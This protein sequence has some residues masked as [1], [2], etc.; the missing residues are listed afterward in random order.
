MQVETYVYQ[1]IAQSLK[2]HGVE[3]IF[4][5]M[6]DANLFMVDSFVRDCSGRFVPAAH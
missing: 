4:G 5:L 1:N 3:T 6:G 2:D